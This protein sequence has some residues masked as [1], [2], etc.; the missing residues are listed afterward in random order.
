MDKSLKEDETKKL[1]LK[2]NKE[3]IVYSGDFKGDLEIVYEKMPLT[4][5]NKGQEIDLTAIAKIGKGSDHSKFSPGFIFYRRDCEIILDKDLL[6]EVKEVFPNNI[7]KEK[8]DKII[9]EDDKR[10]SAMDFA[11]GLAV[12]KGKK[13]EIKD[14]ENLIITVESFGQ[15]T[16]QEIFK[17]ALEI[18]KKDLKEIAKKI[19]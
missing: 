3:G 13:A 14:K 11:E 4:I 7:I 5:L 15:I 19:E 17:K 9:I 10:K 1:K 6:K 12:R 16:P 18:L 8:G 2:T